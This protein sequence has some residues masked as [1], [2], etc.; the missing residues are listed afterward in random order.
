MAPG[1]C[2]RWRWNGA[3]RPPERW[4]SPRVS[5]VDSRRFVII[6]GAVRPLF[7]TVLLLI[8]APVL[9]AQ[10]NIPL[11]ERKELPALPERPEPLPAPTSTGLPKVQMAPTAPTFPKRPTVAPRVHLSS[12]NATGESSVQGGQFHVYGKVKEQR[13]VLLEEAERTRRTVM[14]VL[15]MRPEFTTPIVVQIRE[16]SALGAG[17]ASVWTSVAQAGDGFRI[18]LNLVPQRGAVDGPLLR[19]EIVR[20]ILAE[21]ML[22]PHAAADLAGRATPPPDWMLHGLLELLDY[23]S[24]GRPSD[25]FSAV[26][27]L[28]HVLSLE[29]IFNFDPDGMDSVS[30]AVYRASA[31]GLLLMLLERSSGG[32]NF[33]ALCDTIALMPDND[34]AAIARTYPELNSSGNSLGKWWS[35]QLAGMAQPGLDELLSTQGTE[36]ELVKALVLH[37]PAL[38]QSADGTKPKKGLARVFSKKKT[39]EKAAPA[40][41][42]TDADYPLEE[43]TRAT[44][45]KDRVEIFN[46]VEL[47]LTQLSLRAHPLYRP[48]IGRYLALVK[49]LSAG[50]KEK[51]AAR[52]IASLAAIRRNL[53]SDMSKVEDYLNWYEAT[54]GEGIS[55]DFHDY[56]RAAEEIA[57]PPAPRRDPF[58]RYLNLMESEYQE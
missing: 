32:K 20:C 28:G 27:R 57:R 16:A 43:Y 51:E 7:P 54:Q 52:A 6:L 1:M 19:R 30:R 14:T 26:F 41:P 23:Q 9:P 25:A 15:Q 35:L 13:D 31:C 10:D 12:K 24:M 48:V 50:K 55:G 56:L 33:A 58:S 46:Q 8:S 17:R 47:A 3:N 4:P 11:P 5:R 45:R 21:R 18:E 42:A 37:L 29:D 36:Q 53:L 49:D 34:I 39:G 38:P 2:T 44:G 40:A 22:R